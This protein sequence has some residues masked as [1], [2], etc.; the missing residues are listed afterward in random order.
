MWVFQAEDFQTALTD[1]ADVR[2]PHPR[3]VPQRW[4][5]G[6]GRRQGCENRRDCQRLDGG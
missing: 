1:D 2:L 5:K 4:R 6:K 3:S